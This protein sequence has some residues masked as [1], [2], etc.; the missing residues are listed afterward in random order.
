M[1]F[2]I[3]FNRTI[4]A[5]VKNLQ[6]DV[7]GILDASG[8]MVVENKYDAWGTLIS[9]SSESTA[10]DDLA[11]DN[12]FRYRG[13]VWDDET[14]LYYL[15]SRY[16][17]PEWGRFQNSDV[18]IENKKTILS[19]NSMNY[20]TNN[21][22]TYLDNGGMSKT[23]VYYYSYTENDSDTIEE[24][25]NSPYFDPVDPS[26]IMIGVQNRVEFVRYWNSMDS[27]VTDIYIF[28]FTVMKEIWNFAMAESV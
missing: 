25:F 22:I 18:I 13:Y 8:N 7:V 9:I 16:Y 17:N 12:P 23:Y 10:V 5:Y 2:R 14:G 11:F 20:C 3:L 28:M 27:N 26:V 6:G 1:P 21:P 24:A 4:Y 19:N 15:R